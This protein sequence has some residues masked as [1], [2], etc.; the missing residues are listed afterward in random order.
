MR[1][2]FLTLALITVIAGLFLGAYLPWVKASSYISALRNLSNVRSID[3]FVANFDDAMNMYSPV[4]NEEI[5]KFLSNDILQLVNQKSQP[6]N[7]SRALANYIEPH[8]LLDNPR[9]LLMGAQMYVIFWSKFHKDE[10]YLRAEQYYL[11][12]R[13]IGPRLP[14]VLYGLLDLYRSKGNTEKMRA[15][16]KDILNYWPNDEGTAA[17][18]K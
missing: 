14:P 18:L 17:L 13:A 4:G 9:H 8:L 5:V 15:V 7:V 16:A 10:D 11:A 2:V 3:G 6:E 12:A 1:Q